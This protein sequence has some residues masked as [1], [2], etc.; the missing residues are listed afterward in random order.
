M[1]RCYLH[2]P[3]SAGTSIHLALEAALPSG[4]MAP[5]RSDTAVFGEFAGYDQLDEPARALVAVD[6]DEVEEL[7]AY[8]VVSGH[9]ALPTLLRLTPADRVATVLREPR[10]R[11]LSTFMFLR[12]KPVAAFWG[13]LGREVLGSAARSLEEC[14]SAPCIAATTD[15]Q[16]CRLVLHG[17]RRIPAGGFIDA[18]DAA[19]L[20][21]ATLERLASLGYVGLLEHDDVWGDISAFFGVEL[22]PRRAN[23]S[24]VG[25]VPDAALPV[26]RPD[27]RLALDLI[28]ARSQAD[29]IV[30]ETLLASRLGSRHE[31]KRAADAAFAAELVRFGDMTG[32]AATTLHRNRQ[33]LELPG[34]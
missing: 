3:K 12:L 20:A 23:V 21:D 4:S 15:N 10:A 34:H 6:R 28:E 1:T 2:V 18:G 33:E 11:A 25:G 32:D 5:R 16:V 30:Y 27:M 29:R 22:T 13:E 31:A 17:D 14:L 19:A 8:R 7:R 9:F 26:P 24:G